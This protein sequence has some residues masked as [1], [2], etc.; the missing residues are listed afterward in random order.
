M[1]VRE[2][3]ISSN[4]GTETFNNLAKLTQPELKSKLT[5]TEKK[6]KVD[7]KRKE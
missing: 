2:S 7:D 1:N 4:E 3:S 6:P 5:S